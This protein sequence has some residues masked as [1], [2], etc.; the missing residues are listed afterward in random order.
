MQCRV[1]EAIIH[2]EAVRTLGDGKAGGF[3]AVGPDPG[4]GALCKE[5]RFV[6]HVAGRAAVRI[7]ADRAA[8]AAAMA[9]AQDMGVMAPVPE[10]LDEIK[11][12]GSCRCRLW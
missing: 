2:N 10:A 11:G 5:E 3:G 12:E 8:L 1:L 6:A 4:R 7:D 9:P